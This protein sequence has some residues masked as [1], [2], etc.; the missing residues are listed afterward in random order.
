MCRQASFYGK[1]HK[2][3]L[4]LSVWNHLCGWAEHS[5]DAGAGLQ[6][7]SGAGPG[8]KAAV[9]PAPLVGSLRRFS[10]GSPG[11]PASGEWALCL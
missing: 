5:G 3:T 2:V 10:V 8:P 7:L 4:E 9:V 11:T 6:G 1:H